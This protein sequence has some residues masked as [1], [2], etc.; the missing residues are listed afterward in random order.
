MAA[1]PADAAPE[2]DPGGGMTV[3]R[4]L[5]GALAAALVTAS[6][7]VVSGAPA[8][9]HAVLQS[10]TPAD[11][12][13]LDHAPERIALTFDEPVSVP[14]GGLRVYDSEGEQ[15][16]GGT[17]PDTP[18]EVVAGDLPEEL[19]EGTYVVT[20]R[21][22]STDGHPVKGAFVFSVGEGGEVDESLVAQLFSGAGELPAAIAATVGR[23][24]AYT[25]TLLAVGAVV[26][27]TWVARRP[28]AGPD[29]RARLGRTG[30]AAAGLGVAAAL[31]TV[32]LQAAQ[33]SGA[34]LA[35]GFVRADL[36]VEAAAS[37]VGL[38]AAVQTVG[39]VAVAVALRRSEATWSSPVA[40][41]GG[42]TALGALLVSGH[43]RTVEP[44]WL[45]VG[46]DAVHLVAAA[47]WFG[48]LVMLA[49]VLRRRRLAD[50]P[51]GGARLVARFSLVASLALVGVVVAGL[52]MSWA[53]VR[54]PRALTTTAFGWTLLVKTALVAGVIAIGTYNNRRL[55][56]AVRR[57]LPAS[58]EA[59]PVPAGAA[60][61]RGARAAERAWGRLTAT[62]AFE[63]A[64]LVAVLGVTAALVYLQ[65]AAEAAGVTGAYSTYVALGSD[66]EVNVVVDPNRVGRNEIHLYLL[67]ETGR[68]APADRL[69]L[70]LSLPAK[71]IG[72]ITR[73]PEVA[74]PGHWIQVGSDL[75]IPG[76][77]EL[78]VQVDRSR[79][80]QLRT[81]VPV[82]VN[83]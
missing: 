48:G 23:W 21:V 1:V 56:P 53:L 61:D 39:L 82:T 44:I 11:G 83:P 67:D 27:L 34:G 50:D 35:A 13:S 70:Q 38:T 19:A 10:T 6:L 59:R 30:A 41:A 29:E 5:R 54:A 26:F 28:E 20:W 17:L 25:A 14:S 47:A 64:G 78:T 51:V 65:P 45:M 57:L 63:A 52:A 31:L 2:P 43:T 73:R 72:P 3:P 4:C 37:S 77:W 46:A 22:V 42:A 58:V 36:L 80:E 9:A 7:L 62:V 55:V 79:F 33:V 76:R 32:P 69:T 16:A 71:D 66:M 49:L 74:G 12:T 18:P 75:S 81:T 60:D 68:P 15:V 24:A 40:L 8:D